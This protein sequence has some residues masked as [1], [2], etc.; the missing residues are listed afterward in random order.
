[1]SPATKKAFDTIVDV[2]TCADGGV[3]FTRFR[4]LVEEIDR[5][6]EEEANLASGQ[7]IDIVQQFA[8]LVTL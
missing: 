2:I 7:I 4:N 8:K 5:Q 3:Q 6:S 1:M